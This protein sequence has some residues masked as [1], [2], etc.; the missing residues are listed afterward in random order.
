MPEK[1]HSNET[2][3]FAFADFL[4]LSVHD[5][6]NS[7]GML[8]G[9]LESTIKE[10]Q[11][12]DSPLSP[13]LGQMEYEAKRLNN[14]LLQLL[15]IYK[16]RN[17]RYPVDVQ[18]HAVRTV[19]EEVVAANRP[20]LLFRGIQLDLDCPNDVLWY[21]DKELICGALN[22]ALN[23]SIQH[24][25]DKLRLVARVADGAL[26]LRVEDNGGG[27]P[28]SL[29]QG[30]I[31]ANKGIHYYRGST[32]LGMYFSAMVAHLHQNDG[33]VGSLTIENGGAYGGGCFVLRLP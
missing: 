18:E 15:C 3:S 33:N 14:N 27:Y 17:E 32:G 29:L 19:L 25:A 22:N 9:A 28:D 24:T 6:K 8:I 23:N 10:A 30:E 5:M 20:Q 2:D 12:S 4:A 11:G 7:L 13:R 16:I 26:T 1:D 31:A 21:F